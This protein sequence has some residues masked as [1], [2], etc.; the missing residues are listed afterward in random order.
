[1]FLVEQHF[2]LPYIIYSNLDAYLAIWVSCI[3]CGRSWCVERSADGT[4]NYIRYI[5][6]LMLTENI[7]I[8]NYLS[9][10]TCYCMSSHD[11]INF[12]QLLVIYR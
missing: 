6:F 1:M 9:Y 4:Q 7:F 10:L 11:I 2:V 3:F 8:V 12:V 5:I